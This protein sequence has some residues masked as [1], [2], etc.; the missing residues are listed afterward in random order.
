MVTR[1]LYEQVRR[2]HS[3]SAHML[4]NTA[5]KGDTSSVLEQALAKKGGVATGPALWEFD[6]DNRDS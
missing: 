1:E 2:W 4:G 3:R 5:F 6:K